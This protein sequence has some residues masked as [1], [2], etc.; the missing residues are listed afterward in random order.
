MLRHL[1]PPQK[2]SLFSIQQQNE[3]LQIQ[4]DPEHLSREKH[5]YIK[6]QTGSGVVVQS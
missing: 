2:K 4:S 3:V 6:E 1:P 5:H